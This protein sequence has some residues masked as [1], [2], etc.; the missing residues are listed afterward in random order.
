MN[1]GNSGRDDRGDQK[2]GQPKRSHGRCKK[3]TVTFPSAM[4][5]F[6]SSFDPQSL[7]DNGNTLLRLRALILRTTSGGHEAAEYI[8]RAYGFPFDTLLIPSDFAVSGT[9]DLIEKVPLKTGGSITRGKYSLIVL[10][11]GKLAYDHGGTFK[12]AL[13]DAQWS[14]LYAYEV[15]YGVRQISLNDYPSISYHG[16]V[17]YNGL[18]AGCCAGEQELY[19][20]VTN[21]PLNL[22]GIKISGPRLSTNGLW[23]YPSTI[24]DKAKALPIAHFAK[25]D[26]Y[27]EDT[28]AASLISQADGRQEM[29]FF[30]AFGAWSQTSLL[31]SHMWF[32]WGTRGVYQGFRRVHLGLHI[33]DVFLSTGAPQGTVDPP[34]ST[35]FGEGFYA[36]GDKSLEYRL[37]TSD[38]DALIAWQNDLNTR[39][40]TG[41]DI[42]LEF[43]FN[44]NGAVLISQPNLSTKIDFSGESLPNRDLNFKKPLGTGVTRWPNPIPLNVG[45]KKGTLKNDP[46]FAYF[47]GN[48]DKLSQFF[49]VS[50]TFTHEELDTCT[51]YDVRNELKYNNDGAKLL[52]L[53]NKSFYSTR[54]L[55]TPQITGIFNGDALAAMKEIGILGVVGDNSRQNLA[56]PKGH[57]FPLYTTVDTSNFDGAVVIPRSPTEVYFSC[58][59]PEQ[60]QKVYDSMYTQHYGGPSNYSANMKREAERALYKFLSLHQDPY[61]FHQANLRTSLP[62]V[63][64]GTQTGNFSLVQQWTEYVIQRMEATVSWPV[65]SLKLDDLLDVY[66]ARDKRESCGMNTTLILS[67]KAETLQYIVVES[68]ASCTGALTVPLPRSGIKVDPLLTDYVIKEQLGDEPLVVWMDNDPS[69]AYPFSFKNPIK[70]A[71]SSLTCDKCLR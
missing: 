39:L 42:R 34:T 67:P 53:S 1:R 54:T 55:V 43:A 15:R 2:H 7:F 61:M 49:W 56:N 18:G 11:D 70:W 33:D 21:A 4:P 37:A 3:P 25:N 19:F 64:I 44:L 50:H 10:S 36:N 60:N 29:S 35:R 62:A 28:V 59:T 41:S 32:N 40:P 69:M 51:I 46:L 31:L 63:T 71:S 26:I 22:A 66:L 45:L 12:S 9:F 20:N 48:L 17:T 57:W 38:V 8:F 13:S 68:S 6:T 14:F 65:T 27:T 30:I 47:A 58:S 24:V 16:I 52:G 5:T 23:H